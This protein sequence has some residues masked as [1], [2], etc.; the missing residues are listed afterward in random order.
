MFE[1][2]QKGGG[3][4]RCPRLACCPEKLLKLAV[5]KPIAA[6]SRSVGQAVRVQKEAVPWL[7]PRLRSREQR[8]WKP[9]KHQ[10]SFLQLHDL[11][12]LPAEK[13][14]NMAGKAVADA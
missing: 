10:A 12:V 7:E 4:S 2:F 9:A 8:I 5:A 3:K 11:A 14:W 13:R 6:R 1:A